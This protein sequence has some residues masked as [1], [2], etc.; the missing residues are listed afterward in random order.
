MQNTGRFTVLQTDMEVDLAEHLGYERNVDPAG[1]GSGNSRNG[2]S[3]KTVP[4]RRIGDIELKIPPDRNATSNRSP[5]RSMSA[6][7]TASTRTCCR[8]TRRG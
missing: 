2:Y 4:R 7:S 5:F 3:A 1:R 6:G 8:G